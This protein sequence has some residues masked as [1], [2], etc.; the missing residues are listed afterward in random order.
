[1]IIK[2]GQNLISVLVATIHWLYHTYV[3]NATF[4]QLKISRMLQFWY[5]WY[6]A[7]IWYHSLSVLVNLHLANYF[8]FTWLCPSFL[9]FF[10]ICMKGTYVVLL[11]GCQEYCWHYGLAWM[12]VSLYYYDD[13]ACMHDKVVRMF[14]TRGLQLTCISFHL[15]IIP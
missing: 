6:L 4:I 13:N 15:H 2:L 1:M 3:T 10:I 9:T 11:S 7:T 5:A 8:Y 12:H 14:H